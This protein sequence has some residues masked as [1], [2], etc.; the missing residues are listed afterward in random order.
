MWHT[1]TDSSSE[2]FLLI[3]FA[4][5]TNTWDTFTSREWRTYINSNETRERNNT[6]GKKKPKG[7]KNNILQYWSA[8]EQ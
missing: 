7:E 4:G 6:C 2:H 5:F 3:S 8:D 1:S